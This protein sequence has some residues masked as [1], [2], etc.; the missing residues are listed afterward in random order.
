[1]GIWPILQPTVVITGFVAVMMILV[2][3]VNVLTAGAWQKALSGS[4]WRQY[5]VAAILG[6][7]P[8]CLGAFVVGTLYIHRTVSLGAVV[9]CMI[10][11]SGDEAFVMLATFPRT[12]ILLS[13]GLTGV[14]VVAGL[15][16]DMASGPP[17]AKESCSVM[18]IHD[19]DDRC[20]CFDAALLLP[21]LRHLTLIRGLLIGGS[22]IFFLAIAADAVGPSS[23]G[24]VRVSLLAIATLTLF[25]VTT[26]P[27]HFLDKHL[28]Q[29]VVL[30]HVPRIFLWVLG[31]LAVI[32]VLHRFLDIGSF[33]R[34]NSWLVLALAGIV[35][36][37]PESGPHLLFVT[38]FD[39]GSLPVSLLVASSIVQDGH[40]MLPV[41][42]HSWRSFLK[43]KVINLVTGLLVGALMLILG[44]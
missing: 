21:Q 42:A 28:W 7:T 10:A 1:M 16:T 14:G 36:V 15:C 8:G 32:S 24:W 34:G 18:V 30:E 22:G 44:W 43:I 11:T 4:R 25:V 26:A 35:G 39:D 12:A 6:A 9:A 23:W 19:E 40:G 13:L 5:V 33:V 31:I 38:L 41:L 29:H 27:D 17:A 37:V 20:R 2:E 3:Y